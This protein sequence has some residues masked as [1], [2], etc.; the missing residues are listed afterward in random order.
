MTPRTDIRRLSIGA[1][2]KGSDHNGRGVMSVGGGEFYTAI[3]RR[4]RTTKGGDRLTE[5]RLMQLKPEL[6]FKYGDG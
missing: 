2:R 1:D 5:M 6:V 3:F 4:Y